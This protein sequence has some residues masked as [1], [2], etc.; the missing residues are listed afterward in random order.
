MVDAD[1]KT[2]DLRPDL[3]T[4]VGLS[5]A[6]AAISI[7]TLPWDAAIAS[8][9]LGALM[10]AGADVDARTY[11]L[12]DTV[13]WG[14]VGCGFL[15][16]L[17]LNPSDPL[18]AIEGAVARA[19]GTAGAL[20]LLRWSYTYLRGDEGLGLGDVKLSGGIGAWLPLDFIPLCFG[21]AAVGALIIVLLEQFRR[22]GISRST[23]IPLGLFLCPAL[24]FVF[25]L[26]ELRG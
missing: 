10:I 4:L 8:T 11:L 2:H 23:K 1:P 13:T 22:R 14:A 25:F 3:V 17:A 15:A 5:A 21:L 26:F 18:S 12:P 16:A 20:L 24:W 19:I 7:M 6:I 9:T